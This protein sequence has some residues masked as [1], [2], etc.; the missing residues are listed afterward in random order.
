MTLC[1]STELDKESF[2]PIY[3]LLPDPSWKQ[4][5]CNHKENGKYADYHKARIVVILSRLKTGSIR[6]TTELFLLQPVTA[7]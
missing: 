3:D 2:Q 1:S 6:D 4:M 7:S 5:Q